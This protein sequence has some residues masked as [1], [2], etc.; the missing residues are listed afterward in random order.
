LDPDAFLEPELLVPHEVKSWSCRACSF[1]NVE[2][3]YF[4]EICRTRRFADT[5]VAGSV[6]T[7]SPKNAVVSS[8]SSLPEG[9]SAAVIENASSAEVPTAKGG[10]EEP[11]PNEEQS[12]DAADIQPTGADSTLFCGAPRLSV[13]AGNTAAVPLDGP[14]INIGATTPVPKFVES[15]AFSASRN[16]PTS[17][18]P[19]EFKP[20]PAFGVTFGAAAAP[21]PA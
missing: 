19:G 9:K 21:A 3:R 10:V 6:P 16:T 5:A 17:S 11:E 2:R 20:N 4:C 13:L 18:S 15:A 8:S 1:E 14:K 12:D 7:A